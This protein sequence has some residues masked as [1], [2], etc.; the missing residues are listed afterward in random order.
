M[1][2]DLGAARWQGPQETLACDDEGIRE[3]LRDLDRKSVV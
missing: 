1:G 3:R 2:N